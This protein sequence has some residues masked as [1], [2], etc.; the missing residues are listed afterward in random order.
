M[1]WATLWRGRSQWRHMWS[2]Q[3][4][5]QRKCCHHKAHATLRGCYGTHGHRVGYHW[6]RLTNSKWVQFSG[7]PESQSFSHHLPLEAE[8]EMPRISAHQA[9]AL[10]LSY[11]PFPKCMRR[12][13][14]SMIS[15]S[16]G[17]GWLCVQWHDH[18]LPP[19]ATLLFQSSCE[20]K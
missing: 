19:M 7:V 13:T 12:A 20:L 1:G 4:N 18:S 10:L 8:L 11:G 17:M 3:A 15:S 14:S 16:V 2:L 9:D 5:K 6:L